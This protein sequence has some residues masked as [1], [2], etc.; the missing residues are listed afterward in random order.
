MIKVSEFQHLTVPVWVCTGQFHFAMGSHLDEYKSPSKSHGVLLQ[1]PVSAGSSPNFLES[2][3]VSIFFN[4][5]MDRLPSSECF[6]PQIAGNHQVV[7]PFSMDFPGKTASQA[8]VVR[9]CHGGG[10][11]KC[12]GLVPALRCGEAWWNI[13][14]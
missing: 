1:S 14:W 11:A 6:E 9:R 2:S 10:S 3:N 13:Q 5:I 4:K 12:G 7:P 8:G